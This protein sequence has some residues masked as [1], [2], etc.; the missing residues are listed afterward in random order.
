MRVATPGA[1]ERCGIYAAPSMAGG[2]CRGGCTGRVERV[3]R[4]YGCEG[5]RTKRPW[6][7]PLALLV[8]VELVKG[9]PRFTGDASTVKVEFRLCIIDPLI[10]SA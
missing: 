7:D 1:S 2:G 9:A 6:V 10:A 4:A 5:R 8:T 3:E